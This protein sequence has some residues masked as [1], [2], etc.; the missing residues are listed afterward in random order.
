MSMLA[1]LSD[2][3]FYAN[4]YPLYHKLREQ[5]S[6]LYTP[7]RG[8]AWLV[9]SFPD[10]SD[11]LRD[12][13]LS[14]ARAN[15]FFAALPPE[16]RG[17][18]AELHATLSRW[19]LFYDPPRHTR[20]RKL[21]G[22]AFSQSSIESLRAR[23]ERVVSDLLQPGLSRGSMD[24]ITE[25]AFLVPIQVIVEMLGVPASRRDDF[26]VWSG[27]IGQLTGGAAPTLE[28]C[29][30]TQQSVRS[31]IEFLR[32]QV[33]ERRKRPTDD[34]LSM[35]VNAEEDG[36]ALTEDELYAQ[37]VMLLFAGHETTRNLIG[38]G[39]HALLQH[40]EQLAKLRQDPT[41]IR[42]AVEEMLRFDS[43]V[44]MISRVI[45][46]DFEWKGH[47][48]KQGQFA[49]LFIAGANRDP[50]YFP[51]PDEFDITRR[52]NKHI[53]FAFGPHVCLGAGLARLEGQIA[54]G[55]LLQRAPNLRMTG[56]Q[57]EY[58]TNLVLRGLK[59][60]NVTF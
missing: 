37:C 7:M 34:I 11:G 9:T 20:L 35:L 59:Q 8:G 33:A 46:T 23:I 30:R 44:Q 28:V 43:P 24:L 45:T 52:D 39:I 53:A 5:D 4:P 17:E 6:I 36:D 18:F 40:P 47:A 27:D 58:V 10:V 31:M 2:P 50:A 19:L 49:M 54:I 22:K 14:N 12:P 38:N 32:G 26:I 60:L 16:A 25:F 29:R 21:L 56:P 13:R 3:S 15:A 55:M 51:R 1:Q 42:P 57:P 48:L 41:L